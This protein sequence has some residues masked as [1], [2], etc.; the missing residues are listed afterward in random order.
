MQWQSLQALISISLPFLIA[1]ITTGVLLFR[2]RSLICFCCVIYELRVQHFILYS[3]KEKKNTA[4]FNLID[5]RTLF[6]LYMRRL[7]KTQVH[8][9]IKHPIAK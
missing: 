3:Q 1:L 8:Y 6:V 5:N 4:V 2:L 7:L 9:A